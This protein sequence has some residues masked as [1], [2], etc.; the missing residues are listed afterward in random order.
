[1]IRIGVFQLL[2][3]YKDGRDDSLASRN[4]KARHGVRSSALQAQQNGGFRLPGFLPMWRSLGEAKT[5]QEISPQHAARWP[6][7]CGVTRV[8]QLG[9]FHNQGLHRTALRMLSD[10][11]G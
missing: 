2:G 8:N 6:A 3:G 9:R 11:S 5:G 7:V 4:R 1:M 10:R